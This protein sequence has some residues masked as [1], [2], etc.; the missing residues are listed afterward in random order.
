MNEPETS[1][2]TADLLAGKYTICLEHHVMQ[3]GICSLEK[4]KDDYKEIN[5]KRLYSPN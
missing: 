4:G 5:L 2:T 1:K 3:V